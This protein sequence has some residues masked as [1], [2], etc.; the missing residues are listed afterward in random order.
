MPA[1]IA[2]GLSYNVLRRSED[3]VNLLTFS[4]DFF[5]AEVEQ[6]IDAGS[7]KSNTVN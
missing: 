2:Y 6:D 5:L 3:R 1:S 4:D 7:A